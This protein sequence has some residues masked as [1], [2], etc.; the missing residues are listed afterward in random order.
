VNPS[1]SRGV[2]NEFAGVSRAVVGNGHVY[3]ISAKFAR[4]RPGR[5]TNVA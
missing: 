2:K 3:H 5:G 4:R 1:C